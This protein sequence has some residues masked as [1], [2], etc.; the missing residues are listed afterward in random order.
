MYVAHAQPVASVIINDVKS[1]QSTAENS[2]HT[3]TQCTCIDSV[4]CSLHSV[5][6]TQQISKW[7][8]LILQ[9]SIITTVE[10]DD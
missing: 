5:T 4:H 6:C 1:Q 10:K 8:V 3:C 2:L 9:D 7:L